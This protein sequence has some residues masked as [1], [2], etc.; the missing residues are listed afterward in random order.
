MEGMPFKSLLILAMI[1][2]VLVGCE[3]SKPEAE[4]LTLHQLCAS[5]DATSSQVQQFL[6]FGADINGMH[7]DVGSPLMVAARHS[8]IEVV[9]VLLEAGAAVNAK[10][11]YGETPLHGAASW[12]ENPEVISVLLKAGADVNAKDESGETPL[13]VAVFT[14][15]PEVISVLLKAQM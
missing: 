10:D 15:D 4:Y 6:E 3:D 8:N 13:H 11:E 1:T 7:T 12:N 5:E 14:Q 9:S 2:C